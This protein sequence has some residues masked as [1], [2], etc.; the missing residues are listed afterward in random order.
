MIVNPTVK[1]YDCG[2]LVECIRE[3]LLVEQVCVGDA[4]AFTHVN[5]G[6]I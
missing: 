6:G 1:S 5:N 3:K 4:T 2:Q